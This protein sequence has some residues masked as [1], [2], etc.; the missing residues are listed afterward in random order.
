MVRQTVIANYKPVNREWLRPPSKQYLEVIETHEYK[1]A[2]QEIKAGLANGQSKITV[3]HR[4]ALESSIAAYDLGIELLLLDFDMNSGKSYM[5]GWLVAN[6]PAIRKDTGSPTCM[7]I[8]HLEAINQSNATARNND[9][10]WSASHA[11]YHGDDFSNTDNVHTTI[12]SLKSVKNKAQ[13]TN[14]DALLVDEVEGAGGFIVSDALPNKWSA[15]ESLRKAIED[16]DFT[17]FTDA[18]AGGVTNRFIQLLTNKPVFTIKSEAMVWEHVNGYKIDGQA[19]GVKENIKQLHSAIKNNNAIGSFFANA[20]ECAS[21]HR[22]ISKKLNLTNEQYP[23]ITSKTGADE[24][25][26]SLKKNP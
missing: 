8:C 18:H 26:T 14:L 1:E 7:S 11:D 4:Y 15:I 22:K 3:N 13:I 17:V 21:V 9:A 19:Q 24:L 5:H 10:E 2:Y 6:H 12:N 25:V 23:L 16:T 20:D